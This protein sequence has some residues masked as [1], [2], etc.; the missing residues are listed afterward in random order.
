[1]AII[2]V[3]N[4]YEKTYFDDQEINILDNIN[5]EV[6]KGEIVTI[7]G[8]DENT[9]L[10]LLSMLSGLKKPTSGK[11]TINKDNITKIKNRKLE[12][13]R[14][15]DLGLF[16][17]DLK[18]P[19]TLTILE[20]L[21]LIST[22][23]KKPKKLEEVLKKLELEDKKNCYPEELSAE[24]YIKVLIANTIIKNPKIMIFDDFAKHID[25]KTCK[26]I[27]KYLIQLSKKEKTTIIFLTKNKNI[28]SLSN[29]TIILKQGKINK[30]TINKK[31]KA[32]GELK[33]Q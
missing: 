27:I 19:D 2:S 17:N 32:V 31:T 3:K 14:R 8:D 16:F 30:I 12:K 4:I 10:C 6:N 25:L 7:K 22:L 23:S 15:N 13:T 18:M 9:S 21:T 28:N 26:G 33:W 1:M 24:D 20:N 11:I 29:K 5:F